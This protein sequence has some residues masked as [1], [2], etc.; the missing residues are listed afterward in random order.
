MIGWTLLVASHATAA[1]LAVVLG[2]VQL[3]RRRFGDRLHRW[4]G[5]V[6]VVLMLF[7]AVSSFWIREIRPGGFSWIHILSV[8][9][10][11]SL[12]VAVVAIRRGD[13]TTHAIS[14][15]STYAGMIGALI[16]VVAVPVRLV[17]RW[18]QADWLGMTLLTAAIA[19]TALTCIA[20]LSVA[21]RRV[22]RRP[23]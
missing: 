9:T 6:W 13:R 2:A 1:T 5:R 11:V 18:F 17:P 19:A 20:L 3:A 16:G 14:M 15:I 23:A 22:R 8:V 7:V 21:A 10:A 12:V 4:N